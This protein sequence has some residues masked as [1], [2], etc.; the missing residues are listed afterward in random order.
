MVKLKYSSS[1]A[2]AYIWGMSDVLELHIQDIA[3]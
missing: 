3:T 2:A 1:I